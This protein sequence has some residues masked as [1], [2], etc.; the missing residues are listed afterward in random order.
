MVDFS[1]KEDIQSLVDERVRETATLEFK[2]A[3]PPSEKNV[4]L[5]KDLAAMANAGGGTI[6]VGIS[7]R[8]SR[9]EKLHPF[10]LAGKAERIAAIARQLIDEPLVLGD[11]ADVVMNDAG[12]GVMVIRVDPSDRVPHL[13]DGQAWGRS[14]PS[15]I[16][17]SR[18]EIGRLFASTGRAFVEEFG[19]ATRRPAAPRA[20]IDTERRQAGMDT[21]GR[22]S[23]S[24][25]YRLI[26]QNQGEEDAHDVEMVFLNEKG[27]PDPE[28]TAAAVLDI[29]EG[30]VKHLLAG[31]S[32][33]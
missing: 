27:D 7:E 15:N 28:G 9:A 23:Y 1:T 25:Y 21:K 4:A 19:V 33:T 2:R 6:I 5:A 16:T 11:I 3:L 17:L 24:T 31:H 30:P 32:V 8:F 18:A 26:L 20:M 10:E 22:I 12:E 29:T 13:V 14:G